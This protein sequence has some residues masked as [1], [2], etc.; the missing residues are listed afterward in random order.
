MSFLYNFWYYCFPL[1][2]RDT[3]N[4][5]YTFW[6]SCETKAGA[7]HLNSIYDGLEDFYVLYVSYDVTAK[8]IGL[9]TQLQKL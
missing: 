8:I 4:D 1:E 9:D 2:N 6:M 3:E 5:A 7:R